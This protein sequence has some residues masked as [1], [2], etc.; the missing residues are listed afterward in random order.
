MRLTRELCRKSSA[1]RKASGSLNQTLLLR[2]PQQWRSRRSGFG[3]AVRSPWNRP[4]KRVR[5]VSFVDD[6]DKTGFSAGVAFPSKALDPA[7][8]FY[9]RRPY[10]VLFRRAT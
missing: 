1:T 9:L 3:P 5:A 4:S 8:A 6:G 7:E 2:S 10:A